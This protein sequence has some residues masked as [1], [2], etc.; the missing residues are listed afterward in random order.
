[1]ALFCC[2][3]AP[4]LDEDSD[5]EGVGRHQHQILI[6]LPTL[7]PPA[8]LADNCHIADC[9][10]PIQRLETA[11]SLR[12]G[13]AMSS[14][15]S[16]FPNHGHI[17][18][19]QL[20]LEE[21]EADGDIDSPVT[22]RHGG[23]L[24]AV[25]SKFSR[26]RLHA[27]SA[28]SSRTSVGT[29]DEEVARRAELKRLMHRRIQE[30][31]ENEEAPTNERSAS[32]L[33]AAKSVTPAPPGSGP[34]D[35]LEF[36]IV[37][38]SLPDDVRSE[39]HTNLKTSRSLNVISQ[40]GDKAAPTKQ[41]S[42]ASSLREERVLVPPAEYTEILAHINI[43]DP[44][45]TPLLQPTKDTPAPEDMSPSS[46]MLSPET[47]RC[48]HAEAPPED[49]PR[50]KESTPRLI[51]DCSSGFGNWLLV[52][53]LCNSGGSKKKRLGPREAKAPVDNDEQP[54]AKQ[55][56]CHV[57]DLDL[58]G[59]TL[60]D[61]IS[62]PDKDTPNV[63]PGEKELA[64]RDWDGMQ[65]AVN[66]ESS[67]VY[68]SAPTTRRHTPRASGANSEVNLVHTRSFHG[69]QLSTFGRAAQG[70]NTRELPK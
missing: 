28:R 10:A 45:A 37:D 6:P 60:F 4:P 62:P 16:S 22:K 54:E 3:R 23:P 20:V 44:P 64:G 14:T 7:P 57:L 46:L 27:S 21:S 69:L 49:S 18:L 31:L 68:P 56:S 61:E 9:L 55:E 48:R 5:D 19:G 59:V 52:Q 33:S 29:S 63:A 12:S 24:D 42:H 53:G 34:R 65:S 36:S 43:S 17:Y 39:K 47:S 50:P 25:R 40:L 67:S 13:G 11:A 38:T 15:L 32:V 8:R 66:Q 26:N 58:P 2:C 41:L 30:E 70:N 35:T 1:M 51:R